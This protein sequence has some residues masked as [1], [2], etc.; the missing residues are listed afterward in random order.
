[1][2]RAAGAG[3]PIVPLVQEGFT[4]AF[5]IAMEQLTGAP[6]QIFNNDCVTVSNDYFE[7]GT[8][9]KLANHIRTKDARVRDSQLYFAPMHHT[10]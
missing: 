2:W 7:I 5:G 9:V 10:L 4:A 3:V 1:M 6:S 8:M